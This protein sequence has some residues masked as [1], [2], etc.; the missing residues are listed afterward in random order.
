MRSHLEFISGSFPLLPEETETANPGR[1]GRRLAEYLAAQLPQHGFSIIGVNAEDWGWRVDIENH[2]FSL[3]IGCGNY[4]E[5]EHGFLCFIEPSKPSIGRF[6]KRVSTLATVER[7][8]D[9]LQAV[10]EQSGKVERMRWWLED[11]VRA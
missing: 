8:A 7:L 3:W 4:E 11:E 10:L 2:S 1:Y 9:A 6:L 5:Y